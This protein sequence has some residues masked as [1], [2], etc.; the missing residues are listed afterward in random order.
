MSVNDRTTSKKVPRVNDAMV[1]ESDWAMKLK[2]YKL[3]LN[4][5][6]KEVNELAE[7]SGSALFVLHQHFPPATMSKIKAQDKW[8]N[9]KANVDMIALHLCAW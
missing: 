5:Y 7:V 1:V 8:K 9:A 6:K 2:R 3:S 4:K